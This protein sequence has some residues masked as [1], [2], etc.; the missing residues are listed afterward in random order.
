MVK[1]WFFKC[2]RGGE[3]KGR[4]IIPSFNKK[5]QSVDSNPSPFTFRQNTNKR[6]GDL[7]SLEWRFILQARNYQLWCKN[8]KMRSPGRNMV[9]FFLW[10]CFM[11]D[12]SCQLISF[13]T[14]HPSTSATKEEEE[15]QME[16]RKF[17]KK[18]NEIDKFLEEETE[19][20][21]TTLNEGFFARDG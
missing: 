9:P 21:M 1:L 15:E 12:L 2:L 17:M 5:L 6:G 13:S 16:P 10:Q 7:M 20:Q 14:V 3:R 19:R 11:K 18:K 8:G 4:K